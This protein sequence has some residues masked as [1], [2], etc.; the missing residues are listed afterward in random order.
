MFSFTHDVVGGELLQ[1]WLFPENLISA[2]EFHHRPDRAVSE[3]GVAYVVQLADL[4]SFY[5]CNQVPPSNDDILAEINRS[6]PGLESLWQQCG[7]SWENNAVVGW[8]NWLLEN[9][10]QG[11]HLKEAFSA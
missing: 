8:Y 7:L 6:L 5:C 1:Q 3:Q 11:S 10:D 9:Y 2:V 4:L